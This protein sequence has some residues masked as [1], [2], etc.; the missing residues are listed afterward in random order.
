[1]KCSCEHC[2]NWKAEIE[3]KIAKWQKEIDDHDKAVKSGNDDCGTF[4]HVYDAQEMA[5]EYLKE[6]L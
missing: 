2:N 4:W 5:I 1:M 3:S 6:L